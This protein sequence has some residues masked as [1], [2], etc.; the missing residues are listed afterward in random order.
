ME[1]AVRPRVIVGVGGRGSHPRVVD[2]AVSLAC[3]TG[4]VLYAVDVRDDHT[5]DEYR[6][7]PPAMQDAYHALSRAS[8]PSDDLD[9][10]IV[11]TTGDP[12]ETLLRLADRPD[13]LLV[14]G[15]SRR[16]SPRDVGRATAL[17]CA[18]AARCSV[19]I[20]PCE[21]PEVDPGTTPGSTREVGA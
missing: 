8:V 12:H 6:A 14:L 16:R 21:H 2:T 4:A 3:G 19:V 5:G 9:V 10:R 1:S 11:V 7:G 20:V 13:D 18:A 17:R 15:R